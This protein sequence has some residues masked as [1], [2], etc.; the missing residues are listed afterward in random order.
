MKQTVVIL[1]RQ[2][3]LGRAELESLHGSAAL[4]PVGGYGALL[5]LPPEQINF[6]RL[7]GSL[8]LAEVIGSLSGHDWPKVIKYLNSRLPELAHQLPTG[9]IR[10]GLSA[11]GMGV[12]PATMSRSGLE[13]KK[14]LKRLGYSVRVVPNTATELNAAQLIHNQ[15]T[16]STGLEL[17]ILRHGQRTLI[18]RTIKV[19]NISAYAAR[20]QARPKRDSQVGMLPPKLAQIIINLATGSASSGTVLDPFCGTGVILQEATLDGFTTYGT[21]LEPRMVE[22]SRANLD[23]LRP[24]HNTKLEVADATNHQWDPSPTLVAAET[25]LGRPFASQ[26]D[27]TTLNQVIRS[28][29]TI[30]RKFLQNLARQTSTGMRACLAV[31]AWHVAGGAV[32]HLPTLDSLE[33]MGYTRMSFVHAAATDLVYHRPGQVVGRELVVITRK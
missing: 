20:D 15:L 28:V 33:E 30:H 11:Y 18:A 22:Y 26:P 2:P 1:G 12:K 32:K 4:Q 17:L 23:W 5:D 24:E 29:D 13:L 3:E 16:G 31:P 14:Q 21:D 27:M 6:E 7:G 8:K 10:L 25:Y 9:K 19:Q